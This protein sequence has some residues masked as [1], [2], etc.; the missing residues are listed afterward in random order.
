MKRWTVPLLLLLLLGALKTPLESRLAAE[1]RQAG[2]QSSSVSSR[3]RSRLGQMGF[4]AALSGF[5]AAVA[6]AYWIRAHNAWKRTEWP[7]LFGLLDTATQLQ[8][9]SILFWEMAHFHMAYDAAIEVLENSTRE[10]SLPL[11]LKA[12][13]EYLALGEQFLLDGLRFNPQ[14][15]RLY[16]LLGQLYSRRFDD[17]AR[18]AEAY[19]AA[20]RCPNPPQYVRRFEAFELAKIPGRERDA[21]T[22]LRALYLESPRNHVPTLLQNLQRLQQKLGVPLAERVY[23]RPILS[24]TPETPLPLLPPQPPNPPPSR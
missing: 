18:A 3:H 12:K 11:R 24:A 20:A 17:P 19:A 15:S 6:D 21:Y 9:K 16:D 8:P 2:F 22:K 10:P 5:R 14:S 1:E 7:R 23:D 4:I 13:R